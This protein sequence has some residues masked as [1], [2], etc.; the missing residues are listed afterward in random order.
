MC[1]YIILMADACHMF[2][3][4]RIVSGINVCWIYLA[5]LG[6]F[7]GERRNS[8]K[9][10]KAPLRPRPQE[11]RF[12][13]ADFYTNRPYESAHRNRLFLKPLSRVDFLDLKRLMNLDD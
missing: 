9:A 2:A 13:S 7:C 6:L 10:Y 12:E 4:S 8:L 3:V 5:K 11:T 1:S